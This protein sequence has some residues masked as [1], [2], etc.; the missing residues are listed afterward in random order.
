MTWL[1]IEFEVVV[2]EKERISM[3]SFEILS[4][5]LSLLDRTLI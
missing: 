2:R 3:T 1:V 5:L 4:R